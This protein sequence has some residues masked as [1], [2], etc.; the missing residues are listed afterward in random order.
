MQ[1]Y[2]N[3]KKLHA[4]KLEIVKLKSLV[5]LSKPFVIEFCGTPR[6]GKTTMINNLYDFFIKSNFNVKLLEEFTTSKYYKEEFKKRLSNM[7]KWDAHME[8]IKEVEKQ[9]KKTIN[10]SN[11]D[12]IL[13][14][15]S[16]NDRQIWNYRIYE[17]ENI[18][19]IKYFECRNKYQQLSRELIDFLVITYANSEVSLKRDF[20]NSISLE[21]R[22]FLNIPNIDEYNKYL[23][24]LKKMLS[25][26]VKNSCIMNTNEMETTET[27]VKVAHD[28]LV[29]MRKCYIEAFNNEILK[30]MEE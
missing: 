2:K 5:K 10:L 22:N 26:S 8:I 23:Q 16:I 6:T 15:R 11:T 12:I 14:D 29:A 27:V 20:L 13:I 18:E 28:I 24:V 25:E 4:Q 21:V 3:L 7:S 17:K 30:Y 9:L 1:Y 19:N